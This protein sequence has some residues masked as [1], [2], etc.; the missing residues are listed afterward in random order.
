MKKLI[1]LFVFFVLTNFVKGQT[2]TEKITD[3]QIK[4]DSLGKVAWTVEDINAMIKAYEI[5]SIDNCW[6]EKNKKD[7]TKLP[8]NRWRF[9]YEEK[10][11]CKGKKLRQQVPEWLLTSRTFLTKKD[12]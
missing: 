4:F 3:L 11:V 7:S 12:D 1:L 9:T 2:T 8:L 5:D 6:V 10:Q